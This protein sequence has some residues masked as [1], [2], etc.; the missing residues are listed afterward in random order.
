[1]KLTKYALAA[2]LALAASISFAQTQQVIQTPASAV[3][4]NGQAVVAITMPVLPHIPTT[5]EI[6]QIA[7]QYSATGSCGAA[8]SGSWIRDRY[9][10]PCMGYNPINGC[11]PGMNQIITGEADSVYF[12][13]CST[14]ATVYVPPP[15]PPPQQCYDGTTA[16]Y[17]ASCPIPPYSG[18]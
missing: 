3:G 7:Q 5:A 16:V 17:P 12:Y 4:G 18:Y 11:P 15:P 9:Y 10:T 6:A 8:T 1:M 14:V 13:S 2:V